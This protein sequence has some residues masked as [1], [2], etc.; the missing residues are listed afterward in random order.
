[1]NSE[2][3]QRRVLVVAFH[4]PPDN[5]STGVLRTLKFTQYLHGHGWS[6]TVLTV[7]PNLYYST[8]AASLAK[9]PAHVEVR[10]S[11]AVD[12]KEALG[13]RGLYPSALAVPDRYWPWLFSGTRAGSELLGSGR[14]QAL[15]TTYPVPTAHWI[16]L[17]LKKRFGLPWIADFRDPWVED[18]M[19]W[20]RRKLEGILEAKIMRHADRV[21][22][23]TPAMRRFFLERYP[24][25]DAAK[26][27]TI[28]NGYD[29][30]DFAQIE[31]HTEAQFHIIYPGVISVGNRHPRPLLAGVRLA[32]DKGW[33]R[34]DDLKITF[35]GCGE[36]AHS[37]AFQNELQQYG[38][39]T[40]VDCVVK[41]IPYG[42][43]LK[44]LAGADVLTVLSE[45]ATAG[46]EAEQAWTRLQVPAK[47]YEYLRLGKPM[48]ALVS[49]GA[50]KEVLAETGGGAP[51]SPD[52]TEGIAAALRDLYAQRHIPRQAREPSPSVRKYSREQLTVQLAAELNRLCD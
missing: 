30:P 28:T 45:M 1:M 20:Y 6:S 50:V 10:R 31:P 11:A 47:V 2:R 44:R 41:R 46:A 24:Q 40:Q 38:L 34:A 35:L 16:G 15:Y 5:T 42:E 22:C 27:V 23:N 17:R 37:A 3:T 29:E 43:A 49:E 8:D 4:Y 12:I 7:P 32:L 26:F 13:F 36:W 33:L 14:F 9:I 39:S 25:V 51:V 52:D 48:L 18:S 19:P 21:I